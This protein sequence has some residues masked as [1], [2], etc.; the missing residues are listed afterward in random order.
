MLIIHIFILC[1][2]FKLYIAIVILCV[3]VFMLLI[4]ID[5]LCFINVMLCVLVVMLRIVMFS[6]Y[7]YVT[8][9][10]VMLSVIC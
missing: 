5:H 8:Y 4:L 9:F 10:F 3:F 7:C 1:F 2:I 6:S